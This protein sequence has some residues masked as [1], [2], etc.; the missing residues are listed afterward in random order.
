[1]WLLLSS[2]LYWILCCRS[3]RG[4]FYL[5]WRTECFLLCCWGCWLASAWILIHC[6]IFCR[7]LGR[8]RSIWFRCICFS[9]VN[10]Y[11]MGESWFGAR[12]VSWGTSRSLRWS[13]RSCRIMRSAIFPIPGLLGN[14]ETLVA[15]DFVIIES[16]VRDSVYTWRFPDPRGVKKCL[17]AS[18]LMLRSI[19][20]ESVGV[21]GLLQVV[22]NSC[23]YPYFFAWDLL[24]DDVV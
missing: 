4:L 5:L 16:Y 1:M 18:D 9:W 7:M 24:G 2:W 13:M 15:E 17:A 20:L 22:Q 12:G 11:V 3:W 14:W 8:G 19:W 21:S 23:V 10:C 6:A